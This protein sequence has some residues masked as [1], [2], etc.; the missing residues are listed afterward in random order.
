MARNPLFSSYKGEPQSRESLHTGAE[1]KYGSSS[2]DSSKTS[3]QV[4]RSASRQQDIMSDR[5]VRQGGGDSSSG[6]ND[7]QIKSGNVSNGSSSLSENDNQPPSKRRKTEETTGKDKEDVWEDDDDDD[8]NFTQADLE[9]MDIM[10]SQAIASK[11]SGPPEP[12]GSSKT[13]ISESS[14][15]RVNTAKASTGSYQAVTASTSKS[16]TSA[17]IK[18]KVLMSSSSSSSDRSRETSINESTESVHGSRRSSS[19][20][21]TSSYPSSL[22]HVGSRDSSLRSSSS[23]KSVSSD[24]VGPGQLRR[25]GSN[26][27]QNTSESSVD[28]S[29]GALI[30]SPQSRA[31]KEELDKYKKECGYLKQQEHKCSVQVTKAALHVLTILATHT[32][33]T[34]VDRLL[35]IVN[36]GVV[37]NGLEN[38]FNV[39]IVLQSVDLLTSLTR[40]TKIVNL[41]CTGP[42]RKEQDSCILYNLYTV[43]IHS[44]VSMSNKDFVELGNKVLDLL[45]NIQGI[46][47]LGVSILTNEDCDCSLEVVKCIVLMLHQILQI[48]EETSNMTLIDILK[49]GLVLLHMI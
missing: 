33:E 14:A 4:Q 11:E 15:N 24:E 47:D 6:Y 3:S 45:L 20:S 32:T 12:E 26:P 39:S 31:L 49:K 38:D 2:S 18:P 16:V 19:E 22:S 48:F 37:V 29:V 28:L 9:Q 7:P 10:A 13:I 8:F 30:R 17:F 27:S 21:G 43:C 23:I 40:H 46:H 44:V 1:Q 41:L 5:N 35:P 25:Q 36:D 42:D 34:N